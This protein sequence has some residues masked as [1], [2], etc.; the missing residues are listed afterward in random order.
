[1]LVPEMAECFLMFY[2]LASQLKVNHLAKFPMLF[3]VI[4]F[5]FQHLLAAHLPP[6]HQ[7]VYRCYFLPILKKSLLV[8]LQ[9]VLMVQIIYID[10]FTY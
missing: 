9:D 2:L 3:V 6:L 4:R 7:K 8:S 5:H 1:M 10:W